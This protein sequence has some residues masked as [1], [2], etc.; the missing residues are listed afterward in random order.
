MVA[1]KIPC[2][3]DPQR[4]VEL[5]R[6]YLNAGYDEVYVSQI[7]DDQSGFLDFFSREIRPRLEG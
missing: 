7:G 3:P 1:E 5:L 2:G 4:H 6:K